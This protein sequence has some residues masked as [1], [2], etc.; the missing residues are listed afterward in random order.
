MKRERRKTNHCRGGSRLD[1]TPAVWTEEETTS[2]REE[3]GH[4][5]AKEDNEK[6]DNTT[7]QEGEQTGQYP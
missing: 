6:G 3:K 1:T 2:K 4:K 5:L 7:L